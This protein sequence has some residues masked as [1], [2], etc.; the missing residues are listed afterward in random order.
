MYFSVLPLLLGPLAGVLAVPLIRAEPSIVV[1]KVS[2]AYWRATLSNPPFNIQGQ[3]FYEDLYEVIDQV[4]N[5]NDVKV[6]VF[7]SNVENFWIAHFDLLNPVPSELVGEA[8]W[9]NMSRLANLPVLTVASI[10]GI[11]RGGGAEFA[12]ALD[13]RFGSKEKA[14]FA[15]PEVGLGSLA[16]GGGMRLVP[17]LTGRGRAMEIILGADDFDADTAALYGWINRSIPDEQLDGFVDKFARRVASWDK[18]AL[19]SAKSIIN[20]DTGFPSREQVISDYDNYMA[21]FNQGVVAQRAEA[22]IAAGLQSDEEFEIHANEELVRFS[23]DGP[24]PAE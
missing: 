23:G 8:W 18:Y 12:A 1:T 20:Q 21:A 15:Q 7:D 11:A 4:A 13:V 14:I 2:P 3:A 19:A 24:W 10:R 17:M 6:V 5:D 9:E 16:G 22:L